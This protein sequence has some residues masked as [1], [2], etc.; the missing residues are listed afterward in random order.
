MNVIYMIGTDGSPHG[1][2]PHMIE[3]KQKENWQVL[4]QSQLT[5]EG[6]PKQAYYP[7]Y[8]TGNKF[9]KSTPKEVDILKIK[10]MV[11][12]VEIL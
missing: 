12:N 8:D 2:P 4:E 5:L 6:K 11:L 7:Q 3:D 10:G 9:Y 1:V